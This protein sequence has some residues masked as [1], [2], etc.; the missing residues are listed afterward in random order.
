MRFDISKIRGASISSFDMEEM[1]GRDSM[2]AMARS[3]GPRPSENMSAYQLNVLHRNQLVAQSISMVNGE[4]VIRPHMQWEQWSLRT[5]E[6]VM[7]AYARLN[8]ATKEEV[9]DFI[10]VH[11]DA[12]GEV[13]EQ[14]TSGSGSTSSG[15]YEGPVYP[16]MTG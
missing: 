13:S 1:T 11:F 16:Q 7:R 3:L 10:K 8:E 12:P 2:D 14:T 6:F 4:S 9:E 15:I 5:Q